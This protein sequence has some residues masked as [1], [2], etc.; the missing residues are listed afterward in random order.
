MWPV[1]EFRPLPSWTADY[2]MRG[3][4]VH[5]F[6]EGKWI[7]D[8]GE[9]DLAFVC[10][11]I[12][13]YFDPPYQRNITLSWLTTHW[14]GHQPR[15]PRGNAW[16]YELREGQTEWGGNWGRDRHPNSRAGDSGMAWA[17]SQWRSANGRHVEMRLDDPHIAAGLLRERDTKKIVT[18]PDKPLCMY[19]GHDWLAQ[20]KEAAA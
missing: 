10:R 5:R 6:A 2:P 16:H 4:D 7:A 12:C 11:N 9:Y 1:Y 20:R 19:C 3:N 15:H 18:L 17:C 13:L 8:D 14:A